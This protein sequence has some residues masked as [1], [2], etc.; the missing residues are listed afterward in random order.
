MRR[1][2]LL[3]TLYFITL[4]LIAAPD[5][6][7]FVADTA[8]GTGYYSAQVPDGNWRVTMT[9]GSK[10]KPG[11]TTVRAESRRLMLYDAVTRK[12]EFVTFSFIVNKRTPGYVNAKG[13]ETQVRLKDRER[14]KLDWDDKL[15]L[16]ITGDN[17]QVERIA[18]EQVDCPTV[19]L[20]GNSTV[21][22]QEYEPYCS[23]GQML[24]LFAAGDVAVANYAESGE[25]AEG[26]ISRGRLAKIET[27]L[28]PGDYVFVEFGHNDQ[29]ADNK[30]GHGAFYQFQYCLKQFMDIARAKGTTI[31]FCTPTRR[32]HFDE[33]GHIK[34][35]HKDYPEAIRFMGE[36][37][38]IPVVDLQEM[39]K[40]WF[41]AMGPDESKHALLHCPAGSLPGQTKAIA[42]DTHFSTYGAYMIARMVVNQLIAWGNRCGVLFRTLPAYDHAEWHWNPSPRQNIEKP[43]GN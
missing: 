12:G 24:P 16:E 40:Q 1:F 37:E 22:D 35:T 30:V 10:R 31:I 18:L 25:T 21:T 33:S 13:Q 9:I 15:T 2:L 8:L 41:E 23:W 3:C 6:G 38:N 7:P 29:K 17:P 19:Y 32:R 36:R 43:E 4:S 11:S 26:F 27:L 5:F 39:T 14:T 20:C 34:D 42:D 28:K